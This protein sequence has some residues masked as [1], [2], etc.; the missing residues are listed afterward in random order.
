MRLRVIFCASLPQ[1][2]F[3]IADRSLTMNRLA[4]SVVVGEVVLI[5]SKISSAASLYLVASRANDS[6]GVTA[7]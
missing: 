1:M 4:T 2:L 6:S 7:T 3:E 5:K